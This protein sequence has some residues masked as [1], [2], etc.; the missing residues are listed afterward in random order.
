MAVACRGTVGPGPRVPSPLV[1]LARAACA[2][3]ALTHANAAAAQRIARTAVVR[4]Q[5][6]VKSLRNVDTAVLPGLRLSDASPVSPLSS[7]L[8]AGRSTVAVSGPAQ[9]P[10]DCCDGIKAPP[11][12]PGHRT[13][14]Q[15]QGAIAMLRSQAVDVCGA[16]PLPS[17][18][19]PTEKDAL[20]W[21]RNEGARTPPASTAVSTSRRWA[22]ERGVACVH[23]WAD[24][25]KVQQHA[26]RP[27]RNIYGRRED[28]LVCA[29]TSSDHREKPWKTTGLRLT[30]PTR[31]VYRQRS[32]PRWRPI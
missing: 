22:S 2:P 20:P 30:L 26:S 28:H 3:A 4:L 24:S 5:L 1:E 16:R 9:R 6:A 21:P 18:T 12:A 15:R 8:V 23:R 11:F 19:A 7:L 31:Q 10:H 13:G 25:C 32:H 29:P 17:Q 27:R 14:R